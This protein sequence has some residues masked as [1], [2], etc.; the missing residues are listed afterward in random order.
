MRNNAYEM[1]GQDARVAALLSQLPAE[2]APASLVALDQFHAGGAE[3]VERLLSLGGV[4]PAQVVV[5]LG[6]GLGGPARLAATRGAKVIGVDQTAAFVA[7]ASELTKRCRLAD[8]VSFQVGD[9][10]APTLADASADRV[11]LIHAQMNIIDKPAL[12]RAVARLLRP[13]GALL[14]WEICAAGVA[15]LSW[16]VPWSLDGTDSHLVSQSELRAAIE[17]AGLRVTAWED[18]TAWTQQWF[19]RAF[20]SPPSGPSL[21]SVID[22]GPERIQNFAQALRA[23]QLSLVEVIAHA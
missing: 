14:A 9:M 4:G 13:G 15:D 3:P 23:N 1:E 20:A 8:R 2:L 17:G 6:S 5:D 21:A 22:R 7:L 10:T 19:Q 16:P 11:L 18:R 12:M